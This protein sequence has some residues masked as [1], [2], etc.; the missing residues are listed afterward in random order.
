MYWFWTDASPWILIW[1]S[2][3]AL[4]TI[5]GWFIAS[6][7]FELD[8]HERVLLG[9]GLGLV[10]FSWVANWLGRW[11]APY[12]AFIL[13]S[14]AVF[15]AGVASWWRRPAGCRPNIGDWNI[16]LW[17]LAGLILGR[18]FLKVSMGTGMFDEYMHLA[19]IST[20][21]SGGLPVVAHF[22]NPTL[23][24]YHY[25]FHLL[26][27]SMM[28]VGHF[29]P[30]S[31][32]DLSKAI[33]WAVSVLLAGLVGKRFLK[34]D[35]GAVVVSLAMTLAGG[36][37]YLLLLLPSSF[38]QQLD[39]VIK[40]FGSS[41]ETADTFSKALV[42]T[43][44]VDSGPPI[45]YPF[46]FL[47]G[48]FPPYIIAHGGESTISLFLFLLVLLLVTRGRNW[49]SVVVYTVLFSFWA[50]ANETAFGL[51]ALAWL[52]GFGIQWLRSPRFGL[53]R[54][55]IDRVTLGLIASF[56]LI[57][58]EGG[59]LSAIAQKILFPAAA[60]T[61]TGALLSSAS[62]GFSLQWPPAIIS[63]HFGALSIMN[64]ATL[65]VALLEMGPVM[66]FL[67]WLTYDW[68]KSRKENDWLST[69]L[70][71]NSWLGIWIVLFFQYQSRRDIVS[72]TGPAVRSTLLML[73]YR[74]DKLT[75]QSP[76]LRKRPLFWMATV[77]IGLMCVSG[78]V[79]GGV[80]LS[81]TQ[82]TMLT[83]RYGDKE[84][85]LLKEVWGRLP[86]DAKVF[87]PI[88]KANI[89][90]GQLTGGILTP[91]PGEQGLVWE[92]LTQA[93]TL[94]QL[95]QNRFDFV[96]V[97]SAWW[98]SLPRASQKQ[99]EDACISVFAESGDVTSPFF[100]K[101]LDLRRCY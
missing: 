44:V 84:A 20:L 83:Y 26:G 28:Q 7:C 32:W 47:S 58:V 29:M 39:S 65:L 36:T 97:D 9:F 74:M 82:Q 96:F 16:P 40:I 68:W 101:I 3:I 8:R 95:L 25:G 13:S 37:R 78:L 2:M 91:P 43:W 87:G 94:S 27:A 56:P 19:L 99:L 52:L 66:L 38:L 62:T 23:F 72:L 92:A 42:S 60:G 31:A 49:A 93:P 69:V 33:I 64:P 75:A 22:G 41:I 54:A 11:V 34:S 70:L 77:A 21:A 80:Q 17:L 30:W 90:T 63:A 53:R 4:V 88:T 86:R 46:A 57:L 5:G 73:M 18:M 24:L 1:L 59:V 14:V 50:L 6:T 48:I 79:L 51:V 10:L 35:L 45:G 15:L 61:S 55:E 89:L 76:Q 98:R 71:L 67:P 12:S 100:L 85:A 81:A